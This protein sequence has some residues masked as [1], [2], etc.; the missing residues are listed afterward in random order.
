MNDEAVPKPSVPRRRWL[1]VA[2]VAVLIPLTAMAWLGTSETG[3]RLLCAGMERISDGRLRIEA[4]EGRFLSDWRAQSVRW[5]DEARDVESGRLR[6]RWSPRELLR[7]RLAIERIEADSLRIFSEPSSTP[8]TMPDSLQLPLPVRIEH[9]AVGSLQSGKPDS[10]PT[11]FASNVEA[12]ISSDGRLHHLD[13]L[14]AHVGELGLVADATLAANPPYDLKAVAVVSGYTLDQS[15]KLDLRGNGSL[16]QLDVDGRIVAGADAAGGKARAD[17]T[18]RALLTPFAERP[19]AS[20]AMHFTGIDPAAFAPDAPHAALDIDAVL[21]SK[22]TDGAAVS[23]ELKVSNQRAGALDRQLIP[24]E[25]LQTGF[26][27]Q[28]SRLVFSDLT[29]A[30]SGGG[31][32]KGRGVLVDR[33]LELDLDALAVDVR[34]MHGD[35]L[36]TRLAGSIRAHLGGEGQ[37]FDLQLRDAQ[38]AI[39]AR[40]SV[41]DEAVEVA[42]L[43]LATGDARLSAQGRLALAGEKRFTAQGELNDFDPARFFKTKSPLRSVLNADLVA[44]GALGSV[45]EL[46]LKFNLRD[47][48]LGTQKLAGKGDID[49]RGQHL[50]KVDV[51]LDALTIARELPGVAQQLVEQKLEQALVALHAQVRLHLDFGGARRLGVGQLGRG[52][53]DQQAEVDRREAHVRAA[54]ARQPV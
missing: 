50:R 27:W 20:L 21:R 7:G 39:D 46:A 14:Q 5:L 35:F 37:N 33:T 40:A 36:P 16:A 24:V 38:F 13:R 25:R 54:G 47:S 31:S 43:R 34:A 15:F 42:R 32:L 4:P 3:F 52:P 51:D 45:R 8:A 1:L 11:I 30:L 2:A 9:V 48:R 18:V 22:S 23:G 17:G 26:D 6:V 19:L 28:D 29:L 49:L 12:T 53:V 41:S 44:S 10:N